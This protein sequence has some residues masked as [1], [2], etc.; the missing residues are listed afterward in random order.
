MLSILTNADTE[1][2]NSN[3]CVQCCTVCVLYILAFETI[4]ENQ[5]TEKCALNRRIER[6]MP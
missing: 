1:T 2:E 3:N 5:T 4:K 6:S